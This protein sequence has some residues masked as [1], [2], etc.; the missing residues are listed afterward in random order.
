MFFGGI[1]PLAPKPPPSGAPLQRLG[2]PKLKMKIIIEIP[3]IENPRID[4]SH[5]FWWYNP[6]SPPAPPQGR[7]CGGWGYPKI[8]IKVI[9]GFPNIKNPR[10]IFGSITQHP[11]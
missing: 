5:V 6:S 8:K 10:M 11:L 9:F 1:T 7:P 3:T 2:Y 4:V